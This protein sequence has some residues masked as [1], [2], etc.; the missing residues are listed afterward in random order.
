M[1][2][3][4]YKSLYIKSLHE[5]KSSLSNMASSCLKCT[6]KIGAGRLALKC[7]LCMHKIHLTCTE[8]SRKHYNKEKKANRSIDYHCEK[9]LQN[10]NANGHICQ[11]SFCHDRRMTSISYTCPSFPEVNNTVSIMDMSQPLSPI[12]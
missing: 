1:S 3:I 4:Y 2:K 12:N 6:V 7:P 5:V 10:I 11:C 9:C 8:I